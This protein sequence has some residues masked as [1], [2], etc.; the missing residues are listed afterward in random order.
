[1]A[2]TATPSSTTTGTEEGGL[3]FEQVDLTH[4]GTEIVRSGKELAQIELARLTAIADQTSAAAMGYWG[5]IDASSISG[6][7]AADS[8]VSA[9]TTGQTAAASGA[10][11]YVSQLVRAYAVPDPVGTVLS[12]A[13]AGI[14]SDGRNLGTLI[15]L[16][17]I[18]A[19]QRIASG[20]TVADALAMGGRSL[21]GIVRTQVFDAG[22]AA[23]HTAAV[24]DDEVIGYVRELRGD[25]CDRCLILAGRVY[26][27][28]HGFLRHPRCDCVMRPITRDE[29]LQAPTSIINDPRKAFEA[30][31]KE[32]QDKVFGQANAETIRMGGD[33]GRVVNAKR[34]M[35]VAET[36]AKYTWE[37]RYY[38]GKRL[39]PETIFRIAKGDRREARRLLVKYGY[40]SPTPPPKLPKKVAPP[41]VVIRSAHGGVQLKLPV[42]ELTPEDVAEELVKRAKSRED[43]LNRTMLH[44]ADRYKGKVA[45]VNEDGSIAYA[46]KSVSS[47]AGKIKR[48][49]ADADHFDH[50]KMSPV[51]AGAKLHDLNRYTILYQPG[52]YSEAVDESVAEL[53]RMGYEVKVKDFWLDH[54]NP[55]QGINTQVFDPKTKSWFELQFHTP[56]S[57]DIKEKLLHP[58][59]EKVRALDEVYDFSDE[60]NALRRKW[61][62]EEFK[63]E[64]H[65][66]VPKGL[67]RIEMPQWA[68]DA[69]MDELLDELP[70]DRDLIGLIGAQPVTAEQV[71]LDYVAAQISSRGG[72][73]QAHTWEELRAEAEKLRPKV[74][75]TDAQISELRRQLEKIDAQY[76]GDGDWWTRSTTAERDALRAEKMRVTNELY[77]LDS[78]KLRNQK[79]VIQAVDN[80]DIVLTRQGRFRWLALTDEQ[81]EQ[82]AAEKN[83]ALTKLAVDDHGK[84]LPEF[85]KQADILQELGHRTDVEIRARWAAKYPNTPY[86][87]DYE[88]L[89]RAAQEAAQAK[90]EYASAFL[91]REG[92]KVP[93]GARGDTLS[94]V[95]AGHLLEGPRDVAWALVEDPTYKKLAQ[96]AD[97][98]TQKFLAAVEPAS[99]E[100][101]QLAQLTRETVAEVRKMAS[102]DD[103]RKIIRP[104]TRAEVFD[105]PNIYGK[106]EVADDLLMDA[107]Y[108]GGTHY[109][110]AWVKKV[111]EYQASRGEFR[112]AH[113]LRGYFDD[114]DRIIM[115]S[116]AGAPARETAVHELAHL[117]ETGNPVLGRLEY[118]FLWDRSAVRGRMP[119]PKQL[120]ELVQKATGKRVGYGPW[121]VGL[122]GRFPHP[123]TAKVYLTSYVDVLRQ[124]LK[125]GDAANRKLVELLSGSEPQA[126][127]VL[128]TGSETVYP[129]VHGRG[130]V[131]YDREYREMILGWLIGI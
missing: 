87:L 41:K 1:M 18:E 39:M 75:A 88:E 60:A 124:L 37:L 21:D 123:Y 57:F 10:Q 95:E 105:M 92:A 65:T 84:P 107:F 77:K 97:E 117:M 36:G 127:E 111:K 13:F 120:T 50:V 125:S 58:Y 128:S 48:D 40:A 11:G 56:E 53:R 27:W 82:W 70:Y 86:P 6:S 99:E 43:E 7:Y 15:T 69:R 20:Q 46:V 81:A 55:Y 71:Q 3:T 14:A 29:Y 51:E 72:K 45:G 35:Y 52:R 32:H 47:T 74:A 25:S 90:Y 83:K 22:R 49:I 42:E 102:P 4:L 67:Y 38:Q 85:R 121:E 116:D 24:L 26:R 30:M 59:Y 113:N 129:R 8:V 76:F 114:Q 104:A 19:K 101:E 33:I 9:I 108:S 28:S 80:P 79:L 5:A 64:S 131:V 89:H 62:A 106:P 12:K 31:S 126:F 122:P 98:A 119:A 96:V 93:A 110:A 112:V 34:G 115:V 100:L 63:I 78:Q 16:P 109:P 17:I 61:L 23:E 94:L 2:T 54:S 103:M 118:T 68:R 73:Y 91:K 66:T 130:D 44:L